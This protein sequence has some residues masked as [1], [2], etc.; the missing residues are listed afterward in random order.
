[1]KRVLIE[2]GANSK[3]RKCLFARAPVNILTSFPHDTANIGRYYIPK[4]TLWANPWT[5]ELLTLGRS[6]SAAAEN[7]NL[8]I[9]V[10]F[11]YSFITAVHCKN[12]S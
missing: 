3:Q 6:T 9:F 7:S 10:C 4:R 8:Y 1:M 5:R 11:A 2:S 12:T